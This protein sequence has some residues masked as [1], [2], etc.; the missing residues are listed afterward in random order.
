VYEYN[1][2]NFDEN[3][4]KQQILVKVICEPTLVD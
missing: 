1:A 2:S 4:D 3:Y